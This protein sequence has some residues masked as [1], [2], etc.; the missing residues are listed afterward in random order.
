MRKA[1]R[2][3]RD[4]R[5]ISCSRLG[6]LSLSFQSRSATSLSLFISG[7]VCV[8]FSGKVWLIVAH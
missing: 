5:D 1:E 6:R 2:E 7:S 3:R 4:K 8:L